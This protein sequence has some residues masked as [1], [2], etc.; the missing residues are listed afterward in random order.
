M[1]RLHLTLLVLVNVLW[2]FNFVAGKTGTDAF[3]PLLFIT[4]R[5][6]VVLVLLAPFL[7][8][9]PGQMREM[10][11][12]G[13]V[14]GIGHYAFMFYAIHVAGSLSSVA[15]ASQLTV[16][17][18]T[19]LAIVLL[20]ERVR[21]IRALAI[22]A[23]FGG[24]VIIGFAPIGGPDHLLALGLTT[25]ASGAMA[26]AAILMRRLKGVGVFNLQ[27]WIALCATLAMSVL[28]LVLERPDWA[29]IAA[30]PYGDY[31]S[32]LYS[33]VGATIVGHGLLYWLLQRYEV[34]EIAPFI[35]LSTLFAIGFGV[36]LAG[37]ALTA[38]IVL[39]GAL[40]LVGVT[41]IAIRNAARKTPSGMRTPR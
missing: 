32:V 31:W 20:G 41:V 22:A 1:T 3:G 5:F 16:P 35:T 9:V 39:G 24:V 33:A 40:T 15:I 27:G 23:S 11:G 12:L 34:T 36:W 8:R 38:R 13:L 29:R 18:S 14:L 4:L 30:V 7:R 28:T 2:G 26:T 25:I 17:F 10:I 37:D 6:A 19:I 21:L